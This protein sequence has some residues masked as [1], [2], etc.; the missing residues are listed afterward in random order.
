MPLLSEAQECI[1][2][3]PYP[4]RLV[5]DLSG[6]LTLSQRQILETDLAEFSRN[7][8][9]QIVIL[10]V[11][12]L[13]GMEPFEFASKTGDRWG[14]GLS[15]HDNGIV[16]LI[17][18]K[19]S[20]EKGTVFIA[21]GKGLEGVIPDAVAKRI[22]E[23]EILPHFKKAEYM[24]GIQ[25]GLQVLKEL[26]GREYSYQDYQNRTDDVSIHPL[27]IFILLIVII[28]LFSKRSLT[29][30]SAGRR[31]IYWGGMGRHGG[32]WR[33]FS[34][35]SGRF[36]GFGGFGGGSFGGGGAGGSW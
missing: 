15:A 26:A 22:V 35:G 30:G 20:E 28:L 29:F 8:S 14:V 10:I 34:S 5:N 27:F 24:E 1:P 19:T 12:D 3:R 2:E 7:T 21:V 16:I 18:P 33:D 32:M 13:C 31:T 6:L 36:G 23:V 4:P 17:K 11:N 25:Q 9:N